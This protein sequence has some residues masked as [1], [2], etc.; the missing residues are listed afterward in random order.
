[1]SFE[2]N[3]VK[4]FDMH[5]RRTKKQVHLVI[6]S[7]E[8]EFLPQ[9]GNSINGNKMKF[10]NMQARWLDLMAIFHEIKK[11]ILPESFLCKY[12]GI[13]IYLHILGPWIFVGTYI[14]GAFH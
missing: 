10:T 13:E 9:K 7:E 11:R 14:K 4:T 8:D 2:T 3:Y 6:E 1:M 12:N 5:T